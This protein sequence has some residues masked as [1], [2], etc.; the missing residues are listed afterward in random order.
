MKGFDTVSAITDNLQA[1][2][3][4]QGIKFARK[5]CED[6]KDIPAGKLPLGQIF[7]TGESFE[8]AHGQRPGYA[9]AEFT[10]KVILRERDPVDSVR[11]AQRWVHKIKDAFTVDGLNA[12]GLADLRPV[13]RVDAKSVEAVNKDGVSKLVCK[14]SVRYR[15]S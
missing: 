6:E 3:Q 9:E 7:Y 1:V 11:E 13:S 8:Y 10:V 5:A 12:G 14:V 2:L 15:E 4:A